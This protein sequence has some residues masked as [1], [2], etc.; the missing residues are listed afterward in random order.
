MQEHRGVITMR[1]NKT[2]LYNKWEQ[3]PTED[4]D[5]ILQEELRKEHPDQEVVLPILRVLEEREK[6]FPAADAAE[7]SKLAEKLSKYKTAPEQRPHRRNWIAGIAAIAAVACIVVMALP[8]TVGAESVFDVLV[9][10]TKGI[11]E[12]VDPDRDDTKPQINDEFATDNPGLQQLYDKITELGV[13]ENVVP[14]WLPEDYSLINLKES[15]LR[16]NGTKVTAIY[17]TDNS[18]ITITYRVSTDVDTQFEK[19]D[20]NVEIFDFADVDHLILVNDEYLSVMWRTSGAECM[21]NTN[22]PKDVIHD[23][24][25]SVYRRKAE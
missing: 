17:K 14:M 15:P 9:R 16:P 3:M 22:L 2:C 23:I 18:A 8:R 25:R 4:L 12:F 6:D 5:N 19:E 1:E 11:F 20:G 13:T 21:L 10:W 24:I 7:V